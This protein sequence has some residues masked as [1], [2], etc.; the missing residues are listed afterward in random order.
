[1]RISTKGSQFFPKKRPHFTAD[2]DLGVLGQRD[3]DG[4]GVG[5]RRVPVTDIIAMHMAD[6]NRI[7]LAEAG[8]IGIFK[9][10]R[11][12]E[13]AEFTVLA[14]Q[15]RDFHVLGRGERRDRSHRQANQGSRQGQ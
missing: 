13:A 15:G 1:M 14:P 9:D 7:D 5:R 11:P 4:V 12:V 6:Q 3:V 8:V 2:D 10:H